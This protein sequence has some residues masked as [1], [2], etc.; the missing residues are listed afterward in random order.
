MEAKNST[1][2]YIDSIERID[3]ILNSSDNNYEEKKSIPSRESLTF[4][5]GH[6]VTASAL[7]VDIRNSS[8]LSEKYTRPK[9]AKI[10]RSYISEIVAALKG[11]EKY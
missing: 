4:T 3:E 8:S 5:N 1:Y 9:Q 7:C 2:N 11:D 6:Y 10:Y